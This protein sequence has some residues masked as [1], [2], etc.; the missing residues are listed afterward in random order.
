MI[1][2]EQLTYKNFLST[3]E[4][5]TIIQMNKS[6]STLI[7]GKNGAGKS[8]FLDALSFVLFGKSH[9]N[10]NKPQLVN[11]VNGKKL[12]VDVFFS[13]G[14]T[15]YQVVRGL[16]PNVFEIYKNG[17]L[18]PQPAN[19][20]DYQDHLE[21]NILKLNYRSFHQVV[22]LGSS[23][24]VPFMS[25]PAQGRRDVVEDLLDIGVFGSMA[26]LVRARH[27]TLK[28]Q[29]LI[30]KHDV[31]LLDKKIAVQED[32]IDKL[33]NIND[34]IAKAK[35]MELD[36]HEED[37]NALIAEH[38]ELKKRVDAGFKEY[39]K[40][41]RKLTDERNALNLREGTL[42]EKLNYALNQGK[43]FADHTECPTCSQEIDQETRDNHILSGDYHAK[44]IQADIDALKVERT[45]LD[46]A[47]DALGL[48]HATIEKYNNKA[49]SISN[50]IAAMETSIRMLEADLKMLDSHTGD[51]GAAKTD[52]V[53]LRDERE[54]KR[55][56]K[57]D[58]SEEMDY[59]VAMIEILKDTG[60]KTKIA[61]QYLPMM[62]QLINHYLEVM[63]FYVSF[64][65]NEA[66]TETIKSRHRDCFS[67]ESFSEGEKQRI[68]LALL[69]TWR[70]IAKLKNSVSTNIL[71]LD[72]TFDSSLDSGGVDNLLKILQDIDDQTNV[73]V[74]SHKREVLENKFKSVI[75]FKKTNNFSR[76]E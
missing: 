12:L 19:V 65:L 27:S 9:R 44:E 57:L 7:V 3:G 60:I 52:L 61:K 63:E 62:N 34:D 43:F 70:Q 76:I 18:V 4:S 22:V 46:L 25:L 67:Y 54:T 16:K 75:E 38:A 20:R 48:A 64:K 33:E 72:E 69:F 71:I 58:M 11:S 39:F 13:I 28:E 24:F 29:L 26:S 49:A 47:G 10:I 55:N 36:Q 56:E 53:V 23:N 59:T 45:K 15:S 37:V 1:I 31:D 51:T 40:R 73:F 50:K 41:T 17:V 32:H 74:I 30:N 2:F 5:P 35:F 14:S 21:N 68:D 66:F 6:P 8:T 42:T